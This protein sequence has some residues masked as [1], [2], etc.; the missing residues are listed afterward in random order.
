MLIWIVAVV[1][2]MLWSWKAAA[3]GIAA[4]LAV[5]FVLTIARIGNAR[6]RTNRLTEISRLRDAE[7]GDIVGS[8]YQKEMG[9]KCR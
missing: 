9:G 1:V 3:C 5:Q 2:W 8:L 4:A 6:I 7:I